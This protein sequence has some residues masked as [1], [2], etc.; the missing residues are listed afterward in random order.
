MINSMIPNT[1]EKS[2]ELCVKKR[3]KAK[4]LRGIR[5]FMSVTT[6]IHL[7]PLTKLRPLTLECLPQPSQYKYTRYKDILISLVINRLID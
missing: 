2:E 7:T 1:K 3:E 5:P 4:V 6:D